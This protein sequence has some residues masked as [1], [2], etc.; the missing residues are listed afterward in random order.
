MRSESFVAALAG[1]ALGLGLAPGALAAEAPADPA[2]R[3]LAA[4]DPSV[5]MG[6]LPNGLRYAILQHDSHQKEVVYLRIAAGSVDETDSERG[7]A[8][9]LEHMA[10][11]GS[12]HFP[13][14]SLIKTFETAGIGF[15]RDQNAFTTAQETTFTLD[16]PNEDSAKLDLA[17]RWLGDVA[18][19]LLLTP[20]EVDRERGVVLSEYTL[21]L[22]P[23]KDIAEASQRFLEPDLRPT[24]RDP[25]GRKGVL[26]TVDAPTLRGFYERWY[27]PENAVVVVVGDE[28]VAEMKARIEAAFGGWRGHGRPPKRFDIGHVDF[29]RPFAVK[30]IADPHAATRVSICR[31]SPK[32]PTAPESVAVDR[33]RLAD[34]LW[35]QAFN[36]R[37]QKQ[38]RAGSPPFVGAQAGY[39]VEYRSVGA[40]CFSAAAKL[41]DWRGA[42]L[43]LVENLRRLETYGVTPREV[44]FIKSNIR[45]ELD[46]A[47]GGAATRTPETLARSI[48]DNIV[49]GDTFDS[50]EEDRRVSL[51]AL[52]PL[53]PAAV[54]AAFARRWD[55][56]AAPLIVVLGPKPVA[57]SDVV[58][59][60]T[61][62]RAAPAPAPPA[63]AGKAV[64]HYGDASEPGKIVSR[65]LLKDPDFTRVVFANGVVLNVKQTG[66]QKDHVS[67]RIKFGAGTQEVAPGKAIETE[68]GAL[69][70]FL[71]G[72][73]QNDLND[74]HELCEGRQ[75]SA[76]LSAGRGS[77][78]L[79]GGT[80][81]QDLDLELQILAGL[82]RA[83]GFRETMD[84]AIP[85]GVHTFYRQYRLSPAI[86]ANLKLLESLPRP[87]VE[88]LPPED[89]MAA[90]KAADFAAQ[91][92]G[93]LTTDGL[94][95]T[96]V[97]DVDEAVAI[98]A[99]ARTLGALPP[100]LQ[101]DRIRPDAVHVR[102][103]DTPPPP[104]TAYHEGPK[105]QAAVLVSW[106]LYVWTPELRHR[107]R[108][109]TLLA[110]VLQDEV[111]ERIRQELGK[112]YSPSASASVDRN[113][114]QGALSVLV[115]TSPDAAEKV[116]D[117]ILK[118]AGEIAAPEPAPEPPAKPG[119][120]PKPRPAPPAG[121][122]TAARLEQARKPLLAENARQRT[123]DSW[124]LSTL[125]GSYRY[126]DQLDATRAADG[127]FAEIPLEEVKAAA[128]TWLSKTPYIVT[129][130]P[131]AK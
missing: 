75:C 50:A 80:R 7:V 125:D 77:F 56:A 3:D 128:R 127:D 101:S 36:E 97:G 85:T 24:V 87:H 104:M 46:A 25:I 35:T 73:A 78:D 130:L 89:E 108:V 41:D 84:R 118:I 100:R 110:H 40:A 10:F 98:A 60:W 121:A 15:G 45:S 99:V 96:L 72:Y 12:A 28:P 51:A 55:D 131:A 88:D 4:P 37:I 70:T 9:F 53:D 34:R 122:I 120:A 30:T 112:S 29:T 33:R 8:H 38:L 105:D 47:V 57:E 82:L 13:A 94:E 116:K 115:L 63:D 65:V 58:A 21:G 6:R 86:L 81:P 20:E 26:D 54:R 90:L 117:E 16:I 14:A 52:A 31:F 95:V 64:W 49:E 1:L 44:E 42:L 43:G 18:N 39:S 92:K 123:Y 69:L 103:A 129:V 27:R 48:L 61:A 106:P 71:G 91:L 107:T 68:L 22:G 67:I 93:P 2:A 83:P 111:T 119:V 23:Q 59:A 74:V 126:P 17:F 79:D 5:L 76:S 114:D 113:G 62:A 11:N 66:F 32:D 124:W 19:G 102:Y 109:V